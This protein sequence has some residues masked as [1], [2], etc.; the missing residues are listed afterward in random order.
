MKGRLARGIGGDGRDN[1]CT[2]SVVTWGNSLGGV[3]EGMI[4]G[5]LYGW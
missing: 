2:C 3:E 5:G 4:G 1:K